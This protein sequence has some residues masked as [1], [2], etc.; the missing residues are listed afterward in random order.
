MKRV[1]GDALKEFWRTHQDEW[2]FWQNFFTLDQFERIKQSTA[3][4]YFA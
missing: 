4:S 3:P 1:A 2:V